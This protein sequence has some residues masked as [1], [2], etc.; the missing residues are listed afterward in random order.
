MNQLPESRIQLGFFEILCTCV[1]HH[2]ED[3][4]SHDLRVPENMVLFL[5]AGLGVGR[6]PERWL[7]LLWKRSPKFQFE[8]TSPEPVR[9]LRVYSDSGPLGYHSWGRVMGPCL[10]SQSCPTLCDHMDCGLQGSSVSGISQARIMKQVAISSFRGSS[11][12]RDW[13]S[14]SNVS[15]IG[16]QVLYHWT[17]WEA[18][19]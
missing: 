15:C 19:G 17:T 11:Q 8:W 7:L 16:R 18:Q 3:D 13:T 10:A 5:H 4:F 14:V 9:V 6:V 2:M 1:C 12:P